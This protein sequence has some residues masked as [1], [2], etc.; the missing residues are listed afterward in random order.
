MLFAGISLGEAALGAEAGGVRAPAARV[1]QTGEV[2]MRPQ[3]GAGQHY[4]AAGQ[5][6]YRNCI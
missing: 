2:L 4:G 6:V 1:S 3:A 5:V